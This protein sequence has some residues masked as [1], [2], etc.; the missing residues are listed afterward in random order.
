MTV[1]VVVPCHNEAAYLPALLDALASQTSP[2]DEIIIVNDRSTDTTTEVAAAWAASHTSSGLRVIDGPGRGPGPAM[3]AGIRATDADIVMRF[4][5]HSM[6]APDY[7]ERCLDV[8]TALRTPH[9]ALRSA[10]VGGVWKVAAGAETAIA[11]AIAAVVSHPIGSGGALYRHADATG[12]A[13]VQVETVPFGTFPRALWAHLGGFDESLEANQDFDF[14]YRAR[15]SGADVILDRRIVATYVA[16]PTIAALA[17]QYL[18]Y[19]FWKVQMLRKDPRAVRLRQLPPALLLPWVV[20]TTVAAAVTPGVVTLALAALYPL[21]VA[22][23]GAHVA[24]TRAVNPVAA[25]AA[26]ATVHLAWSAGFWQGVLARGPNVA[27]TLAAAVL[28]LTPGFAQSPK[29]QSKLMYVLPYFPQFSSGT[30]PQFAAEVADLRL[31]LGEGPYV[32]AGFNRYIFGSMDRWDV[33]PA[34]R[35][36]IRANSASTIQQIDQVVDRARLHGIPLSLSMLTAIRNRYDPFQTGAERDDRRN[37]Q[38]YSNGDMAP[39]WITLSRYARKMQGRYEA[40]IRETG[41]VLANRMARYPSTLVAASGDGEVELSFDRSPQFSA[42][43]TLETMQLTDYSPFAIAEFR[44]WLRNA[45][46]YAPGQPFAGQGYAN[47]ARYQGD[48]SPSAD[49]NGDGRTVNGDFGTAFN[50][51]QLRHFD[52]SLTDATE[53]DPGAIPGFVYDRPDFVALPGTDAGRFDAPRA[54]LPGQPW[55]EV[56][57]RFR[58]EMVWHY[59]LDFARWITTTADPETGQTVPRDRWYS[60]Q[61][62]ADYLFGFSPDN[63]DTRYLTSASP[64]WSADVSP[65][66]GLGITAFNVNLGGGFFARTLATVV[67]HIAQR[68]VRWAILEWNPSLPVSNSPDVYELEMALIERHRPA[69]VVPW[70]WGGDPFYEIRN[71]PFQTAL[72]DLIAR[73]KDGPTRGAPLTASGMTTTDAPTTTDRSSAVLEARRARD[74]ILDRDRAATVGRVQ[75]RRPR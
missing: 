22:A 18:R 17:R 23:A 72:R 57:D 73:M 5:G 61:V 28:M 38:W 24:I 51:W 20:M 11:R 48:S 16:R 47:A 34:D 29:P 58:Q 46:L 8:L 74:A 12:P 30:D 64:H 69:L 45:G 50:S 31:R 14:N 53:V 27:L 7:L 70:A 37:T 13:Q 40:Y 43:Y 49:T 6:P 32:R 36:T 44:D 68:N 39:G 10:V 25:T 62:P 56:W 4:D 65:Y 52:W 55:W 60:H 3:N 63:P 54:R 41:A 26:V 75:G 66:G 19:G 67:P 33:N 1:A 9:H 71:T 59:N 21:V 42:Q 35:A 2:P 15:R